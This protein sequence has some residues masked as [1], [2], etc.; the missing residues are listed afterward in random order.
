MKKKQK[1]RKVKDMNESISEIEK[2]KWQFLYDKYRRRN[3]LYFAFLLLLTLVDV[4]RKMKG[5]RIDVYA[6]DTS[7]VKTDEEKNNREFAFFFS[8]AD[9][10][11][12][13]PT[14]VIRDDRRIRNYRTKK[15]RRN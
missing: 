5:K 11:G 6:L 10:V 8:L 14:V 9:Y 12:P 3:S 7:V 1:M 2:R 4:R 13:L 15:R